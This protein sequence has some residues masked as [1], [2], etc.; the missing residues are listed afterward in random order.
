[1]TKLKR[2]IHQIYV[3]RVWNESGIGA[4]CVLLNR[5]MPRHVS[6]A[7]RR[8]QRDFKSMSIIL[9]ASIFR[10]YYCCV[11]RCFLFFAD[12]KLVETFRVLY[13]HFGVSLLVRMLTFWWFQ[14]SEEFVMCIHNQIYIFTGFDWKEI[15]NKK[16]ISPTTTIHS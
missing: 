8:T 16:N 6:I 15:K 12:D 5:T 2:N 7:W 3:L 13:I 14:I 9:F 4:T 11:F 1:M 10:P